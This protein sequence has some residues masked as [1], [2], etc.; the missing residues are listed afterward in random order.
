MPVLQVA[1][2]MRW[3]PFKHLQIFLRT[4]SCRAGR[5]PSTDSSVGLAVICFLVWQ[6]G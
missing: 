6:A 3:F 2:L 4:G 5:R 1:V